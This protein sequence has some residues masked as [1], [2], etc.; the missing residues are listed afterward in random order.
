[1][2]DQFTWGIWLTSGDP[3][4]GKAHGAMT[5][6]TFRDLLRGLV[7]TMGDTDR[8]LDRIKDVMVAE[9][10]RVKAQRTQEAHSG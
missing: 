9:L 6:S 5:E 8:A 1:M 4:G 10:G 7:A 2:A 3:F